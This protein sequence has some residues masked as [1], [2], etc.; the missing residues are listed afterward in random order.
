MP[1]PLSMPSILEDEQGVHVQLSGKGNNCSGGHEVQ[2]T[3][4]SAV[5]L[6]PRVPWH[7]QRPEGN[8]P[9]VQDTQKFTQSHPVE[10]CSTGTSPLTTSPEPQLSL[11]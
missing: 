7:Q 9:G 8:C 2:L 11:P 4:S 10:R 6:S 5:L 3:S 1:K